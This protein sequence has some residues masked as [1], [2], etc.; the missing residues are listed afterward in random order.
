VVLKS[1]QWPMRSQESWAA[2]FVATGHTWAGQPNKQYIRITKGKCKLV[3]D[4]SWSCILVIYPYASRW[5]YPMNECKVTT[6][7]SVLHEQRYHSIRITNEQDGS[8]DSTRSL[9]LRG[10]QFESWPECHLFW[11]Y[12]WFF[13]IFKVNNHAARSHKPWSLLLQHIQIHQI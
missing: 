7:L 13:S 8:G 3:T 11:D 12:L 2:H 10:A 4:K 6:N 9:C 5:Q 1:G